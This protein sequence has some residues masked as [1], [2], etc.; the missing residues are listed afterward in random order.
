MATGTTSKPKRVKFTWPIEAKP[1]DVEGAKRFF[2]D[3]RKELERMVNEVNEEL[4]K[5]H[6]ALP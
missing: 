1:G 2:A 4:D 5:L 6:D 3:L